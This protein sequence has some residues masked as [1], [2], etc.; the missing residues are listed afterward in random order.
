[1]TETITKPSVDKNKKLYMGVLFASVILHIVFFILGFFLRG[2]NA[3]EAMTILNARSLADSACDIAGEPLPVYFDTWLYGGQSPFATY[4]LALFIKLFG[5]SLFVTRLPMF[6]FSIISLVFFYKLLTELFDDYKVIFG[7]FVFAAFSPW[8]LLTCAYT[9]DCNFMPHFMIIAVYYLVRGVKTAKTKYFV[10]SMVFFGLCFYCYIL[11]AVIVPLI[12]LAFYLLLIIKKKISIKNS[13]ISVLTIFTVAIP[14]ILFGLVQLEIINE[15][16]FLGFSFSRMPDYMRGF[17]DPTSEFAN[18][19]FSAI[20]LLFA[21]D[22]INLLDK[23]LVS[24]QYTNGLGGFMMLLGLICLFTQGRKKSEKQIP[25]LAKTIIASFFTPMLIILLFSFNIYA[26][27]RFFFC[28]Y[29]LYIVIG[30]GVSYVSRRFKR[31]SFKNIISVCLCV[32]LVSLS[33]YCFSYYDEQEKTN[34]SISVSSLCDSVEFAREHGAEQTGITIHKDDEASCFYNERM[35]LALYYNNYDN[36]ENFCSISDAL[37]ALGFCSWN[38]FD[39]SVKLTNDNSYYIVDITEEE[40]VDDE[41]LIIYSEYLKKA[42]YDKNE[43][44]VADF[45]LF[46]VLYKTDAI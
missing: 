8:Q 40:A 22:A 15:F 35:I 9:L 33:L 21:P 1:M 13:A 26:L 23:D 6:I 31:F 10:L 24:V 16:T 27:Y 34:N 43:Y 30:L 38:N 25:T 12:L 37:R 46:S 14:F 19:F 36:K 7:A 44:S 4:L 5:Y 32:S 18:K 2:V 29:I 39:T 17:H 20:L 45:G 11:S 3:D 42:R 28:N 41:F